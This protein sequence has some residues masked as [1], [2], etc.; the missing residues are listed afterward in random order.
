MVQGFCD[1]NSERI[2]MSK[3]FWKK[4]PS[5]QKD[6]LYQATTDC[7]P[8]QVFR[9]QLPM[10]NRI[11]SRVFCRLRTRSR[12]KKLW[13]KLAWKR[14]FWSSAQVKFKLSKS[15]LSVWKSNDADRL[16]SKGM[17]KLELEKVLQ[18]L[19]AMDT[20]WKKQN[21]FVAK[22]LRKSVWLHPMHQITM[23][24]LYITRSQYQTCFE[25]L[26]KYW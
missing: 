2:F 14:I 19:M 5:S 23:Y 26:S 13:N 17:H 9:K 24:R 20:I 7:Q 11:Q 21:H 25:V 1:E 3:I 18:N 4:I 10:T 12:R 15:M 8:F 6:Q 16:N 22:W